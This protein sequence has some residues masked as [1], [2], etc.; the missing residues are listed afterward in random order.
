MPIIKKTLQKSPLEIR[1]DHFEK[2]IQVFYDDLMEMDN[3]L[4]G[5]VAAMHDLDLRVSGA[6]ELMLAHKKL[7]QKFK[8]PNDDI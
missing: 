1:I 5:F 4:K 8:G 2:K 7:L 6:C 3:K